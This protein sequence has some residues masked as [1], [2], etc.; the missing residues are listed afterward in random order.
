MLW[1]FDEK[2]S[3]SSLCSSIASFRSNR[4]SFTLTEESGNSVETEVLGRLVAA[5]EDS[6]KGMDPRILSFWYKRIEEQAQQ[7]CPT[8]ELRKS[9]QVVQN[10]VLPMKFQIKA[11]RR[12]A[13]YVVKVVEQNLS[14]MPFATRLYFQKFV[15]ILEKELGRLQ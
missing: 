8:E 10:P 7:M 3:F 2:P 15:E 13:P 9:I 4:N 14:K 1:I 11:S 12:A 5:I 6:Q